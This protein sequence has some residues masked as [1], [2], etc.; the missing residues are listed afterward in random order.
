[1]ASPKR[2]PELA[3]YQHRS[4]LKNGGKRFSLARFDP[5]AEPFSTGAKTADKARVAE[6]AV[7]LDRLQDVFYA[8][9]RFKMLVV[10]QGM[11]TS[12][13]DGTIRGVFGQ[14]SAL[15]VQTVGWKVPPLASAAQGRDRDLQPQPL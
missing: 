2:S 4:A 3:T 8:D 11:D 9:R 14:M 15:G 10:L 12:G 7:A 13:K 5:G 6:L 1:M